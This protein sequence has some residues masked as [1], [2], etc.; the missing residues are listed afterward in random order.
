MS[1]ASG[2]NTRMV[3][4]G[5]S[6]AINCAIVG[7]L[8]RVLAA[9][10]G[11]IETK[12]EVELERTSVV[13]IK[14]TRPPKIVKIP[15]V[16]PAPPRPV[17]TPS[18]RAPASKPVLPR[19]SLPRLNLPALFGA[20]RT[21]AIPAATSHSDGGTSAG[22]PVGG[23]TGP[24]VTGGTTHTGPG[25]GSSH[26]PDIGAT[27]PG[28]NGA[29]GSKEPP[30]AVAGHREEIRQSQP[31]PPKP[32]APHAPKGETRDVKAAKQP[33]PA[34]PGDARDEGVEGTVTLIAVVGPDGKV[35][36]VRVEKG[37]GDRRLDR[38]AE[39]GVKQW[40]YSPALKDGVPVKA[41]VRVRVE[42][43]LQ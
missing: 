9:P 15:A 18:A 34:Y 41:T 36:E 5:V 11:P 43:R 24:G 22:N 16:E 23:G 4:V 40:T 2:W 19:L 27:L 38:A 3:S 31:P 17:S 8:T 33:R 6:V 13:Q 42:F 10:S 39:N 37:S 35:G 1:L 30:T 26:G 32:V 29:G 7:I 21:D 28:A 14:P 20:R 12:I 25:A